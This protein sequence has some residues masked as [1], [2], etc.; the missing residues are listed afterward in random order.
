MTTF[1]L[2]RHGEPRYDEIQ[3][4]GYKGMGYELGRLTDLGIKQ[5]EERA[6]DPRLKHSQIIISSPYTRALQT[7]AIISRHTGINLVV[8]NDLHEWMPDMTHNYQL[9]PH[10]SF[11]E[12]ITY[13]GIPESTRTYPWESYE[14]LQQRVGAVLDRYQ[15]YD[16]V[17]VVCHG[18]VISSQTHFDD[19]IE[20]CGV[21]ILVK[22]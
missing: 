19:I 16:Q 10:T 14:H 21:R 8:E 18:I 9:E 1:I 3:S 4:R 17:I 2:I 15:D 6:L 11:E 5:A 12:Y 22:S 13:R 20:H 7:A